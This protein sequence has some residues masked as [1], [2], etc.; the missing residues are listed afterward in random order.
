[1]P[2]IKF[3]RVTR[4]HLYMYICQTCNMEVVYKKMDAHA[5]NRHRATSVLVKIK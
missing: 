4:G 3:K 1:M 5:K 2:I